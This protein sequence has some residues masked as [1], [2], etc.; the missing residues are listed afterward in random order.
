M[1]KTTLFLLLLTFMGMGVAEAQ[2]L[3]PAGVSGCVGRWNFSST[4][5]FVTVPGTVYDVSGNLNHGTP[6]NVTPARSL[7]YWANK[8]AAF[9]GNSSSVIVPSS[10]TLTP[11]Q[12]TMVALV[13][14]SGF[15]DTTISACNHSSS[16][17]LSKADV[18]WNSLG[19]YGMAVTEQLYNTAAPSCIYTTVNQQLLGQLGTVTSGPSQPPVGSYVN[20]ATAST[21]SWYFMAISYSGDTIRYYQVLIDT[22]AAGY[23]VG[24]TITPY[25]SVSGINTPLL[26]NSVPLYI[27]ANSDPQFPNWLTGA[28]DEVAIFNR[29]LTDSEMHVIYNYMWSAVSIKQP[30]TS[31]YLCPGATFDVPYIAND[32]LPAPNTFTVQ[33]SDATGS[34][35][36]AVAIG[37][38]PSTVSG[39]ISCTIPIGTPA[40]IGYRIRI[41]SSDPFFTS[42]DNGKDIT[43]SNTPPATPSVIISA[44]PSTHIVSGQ[45]VTFSSTVTNGGPNPIYQWFKN[46]SAIVGATSATYT[47]TVLSNTDVISLSVSNNAICNASTGYSTGILMVVTMDVASL[48]Q[49]DVQ[50]ALFPNPNKGSFS[51]KGFL[52]TAMNGKQVVMEITNAIGQVIYTHN[53]VIQN[54]ELNT[55]LSVSAI[56]SGMYML[57]I[58]TDG[59][60]KVERF[61][62]DK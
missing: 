14:F 10:S 2:T 55:Q 57:R 31:T 60:S 28:I 13:Q 29:V 4:G 9:N 43:I 50:I 19:D 53:A 8:A 39:T 20:V 17:I 56:A 26:A 46:G 62:I 54:G 45:S 52:G 59:L 37:S 22:T 61:T 25:F 33:L 11:S 38:I 1:K 5:S 44:S 41:F 7:R 40:G 35:A 12:I 16:Q 49:E 3:Y 51:V 42:R 15:W 30:F 36:S 21:P 34:F 18:H 24:N 32:T 58:K 48:N 27:G 47:T 6:H 23:V